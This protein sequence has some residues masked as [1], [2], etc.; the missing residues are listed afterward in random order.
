MSRAMQRALH[1]ARVDGLSRDGRT[2]KQWGQP[3]EPKVD[4]H[5]PRTVGALID[6]GYLHLYPGVD[7]VHITQAGRDALAALRQTE[8]AK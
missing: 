3:A 6:R 7:R 4:R 5:R 2:W 8:D 1:A